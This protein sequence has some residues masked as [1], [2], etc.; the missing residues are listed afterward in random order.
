MSELDFNANMMSLHNQVDNTKH[1]AMKNVLQAEVDTSP[2][3]TS[4]VFNSNTPPVSTQHTLRPPQATAQG[5]PHPSLSLNQQFQAPTDQVHEVTQHCP[6]AGCHW[7]SFKTHDKSLLSTCFKMLTLHLKL[8]HELNNNSCENSLSGNAR[9]DRASRE[10]KL[11]TTPMSIINIRD[12]ATSNLCEARYFAAPLDQRTIAHNMP[13]STY[14]T[15][16]VVDFSH[17]GVHVINVDTLRK[18]QNRGLA[19]IR[20][21]ELSDTNLR[22]SHVAGEE[23]VA[24]QTT[25]DQLELGRKQKKLEDAK[26]CLKAF[27]NFSALSRNFHPLDWSPQSLLKMVIEKHL[28]G[29]PTV[30]QY[31]FLF[32]KFIHENS[33]RAQRRAIPLTYQE[34]ITMWNAEIAPAPFNCSQLQNVVK[35]EVSKMLSQQQGRRPQAS[36]SKQN[37]PKRQRALLT[38]DD[39]CPTFNTTKSPPFCPNPTT[40][41][42]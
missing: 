20:L 2:P 4:Q 3:L 26:E 24:V 38:K 8:E 11:A 35:S 15:N 12:D 41:G 33:V 30:E 34:V 36:S 14:P 6:I 7:S 28:L 16:T 40:P 23:L 27:F 22:T 32:E 39:Y 19:N 5:S 18:I 9:S 42:G 37:P 10:Y 13:V 31:S 1:P 25:K 21:R 29:P 17:L